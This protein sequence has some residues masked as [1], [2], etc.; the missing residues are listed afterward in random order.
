MEGV[1]YIIETNLLIDRNHE[2]R[3]VASILRQ[4]LKV[5]LPNAIQ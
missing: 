3:R 1:G 5:N 2:W 4:S